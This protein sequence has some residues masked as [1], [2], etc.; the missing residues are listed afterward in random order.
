ASLGF[1]EIILVGVD[2]SY[3]VDN[4]DRST[5]YG[6]G[7]LTSKSDDVNHFDPRYF[8][9][10]YRWHDPNVNVMLQ[11]YRKARD[12]ARK[13]GACIR[14][15]TVGGQLEVFPRVDFLQLFPQHLAFP[16]CAILDF[17]SVNKLSATGAV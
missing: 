17:T 13:H 8:G 15:A 14:N 3:R 11:A 6:T 16:R 7:V 12:H 5:A 10:G 4:V 2:A 9:S 1:E